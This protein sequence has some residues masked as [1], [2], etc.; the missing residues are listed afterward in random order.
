MSFKNNC[1]EGCLIDPPSLI[2]VDAF[3]D[4]ETFDKYCHRIE[5]RRRLSRE[6]SL[7]K[8]TLQRIIRHS[9]ISDHELD[10]ITNQVK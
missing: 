4:H 3:C 9:G 7:P 6:N 2:R 5:R 8:E 1:N 10:I